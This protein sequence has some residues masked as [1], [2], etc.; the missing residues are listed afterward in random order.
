[1][2]CECLY[3]QRPNMMYQN[4]PYECRYYSDPIVL[5]PGQVK[6][7]CNRSSDGYNYCP[8]VE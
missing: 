3:R 8:L 6:R 2:T 5:E 7:W 4:P 1:M